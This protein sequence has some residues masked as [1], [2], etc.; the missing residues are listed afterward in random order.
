MIHTPHG[1]EYA[2]PYVLLMEGF[3]PLFVHVIASGLVMTV[4]LLVVAM[5]KLPF[6]ATL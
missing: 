6:Q 5:N 3:R 2:I 4:V 1:G